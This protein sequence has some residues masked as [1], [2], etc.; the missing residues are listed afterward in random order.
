ML[1]GWT[2][3]SSFPSTQNYFTHTSFGGAIQSFSKT[4]IV[5]FFITK[6]FITLDNFVKCKTGFINV[7]NPIILKP[8][9]IIYFLPHVFPLYL[10][11]VL[12]YPYVLFQVFLEADAKIGLSMIRDLLRE[13]PVLG[14]RGESEGG[15]GESSDYDAGLIPVKV[16]GNEK[17]RVSNCRAVLK[18]S[19]WWQIRDMVAG[20]ICQLCSAWLIIKVIKIYPLCCTHLFPHAHSR[21]SSWYMWAC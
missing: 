16:R 11:F 20:A 13:T 14:Q 18:V 3:G 4:S 8:L 2:L 17:E 6:Y 9:I 1:L 12:T 10:Y 19:L 5:F 7:K 21:S 15:S